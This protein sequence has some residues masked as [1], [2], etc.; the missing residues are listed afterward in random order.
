MKLKEFIE[1]LKKPDH[2]PKGV[3]PIEL[4]VEFFTNYED[5]AELLSIYVAEGDKTI[6]IDVGPDD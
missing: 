6:C 4:D 5:P 2:L 3:D 1:A